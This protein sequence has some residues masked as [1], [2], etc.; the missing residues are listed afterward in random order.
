MNDN[1]HFIQIPFWK[2]GTNRTIDQTGGKGFLFGGT[3]LTFKKTSRNTTGSISLL[4]VIHSQREKV[5]AWL[6]IFFR[7]D[8]GK[9]YSVFHRDEHGARGLAS[10]FASF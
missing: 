5:L 8:G 1:L 9:H 4:K 2:Q 10:D 3:S 7:Y 6:G